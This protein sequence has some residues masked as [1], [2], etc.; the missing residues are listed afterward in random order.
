M[1]RCECGNVDA[2]AF[3]PFTVAESTGPRNGWRCLKCSRFKV[4]SR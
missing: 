4:G 1:K 2:A 3:E